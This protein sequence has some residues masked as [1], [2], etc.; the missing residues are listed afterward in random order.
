MKRIHALDGLRAI[1]ILLVSISHYVPMVVGG[2]IADA[3]KPLGAPGV[4]VFFVISGYLITTLLLKELDRS[5]TISLAAFYRRRFLRITPAYL[6][7]LLVV[8]IVAGLGLT[9]VGADVWPYLLTYTFNLKAGLDQSTVGLVWSLCVEEHFYLLWP[10]TLLL[11]GRKSAQRILV[12]VIAVAAALRFLQPSAFPGI[13]IDFFTPT[14]L[15]T[16]AVGCLLAFVDGK[17]ERF[18]GW[19]WAALGGTV[20]FLSIYVFSR[21][22]KYVLGPSH[23]VEAV[24]VALVTHALIHRPDDPF[25]RFL[26]LAPM[27]LVGRLSYSLYLAQPALDAFHNVDMPLALR[28]VLLVA[29]AAFSYNLIEKPFLV[30]K[31][32]LERRAPRPVP[33]AVP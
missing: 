23:L 24:A 6:L 32:R 4:K 28:P 14:Q 2:R 27:Q 3:V 30:L 10:A 20:F 26:D 17:E 13:D 1:S 7:F 18:R 25:T 12:G 9:R 21:S 11:A 8:A 15:D 16:I 5:G 19:R 22:G 29:Y 33:T 31:D